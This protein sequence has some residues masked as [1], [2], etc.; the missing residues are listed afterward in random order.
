M[1]GAPDIEDIQRKAESGDAAAQYLLAGLLSRAGRREEAERWLQDAARANCGDAI[2]T[3]A[4][5]RLHTSEG[6]I[7]TAPKVDEAATRGSRAAMALRAV[8]RLEG[9]GFSRDETQAIRD[10]VKAA[11][12]GETAP[13]RA[14]ASTLLLREVDDGDARSLLETAARTD[15]IAAA[16]LAAR[17]CAGRAVSDASLLEGAKTRLRRAHY[18]RT[19]AVSAATVQTPAVA[20]P[21][22]P[23]WD[24]L[25]QRISEA[26]SFRSTVKREQ[27]CPAPDIAVYRRTVPDEVCEYLIAHAAL[28]LGPS[29]VYNPTSGSMMQDPLR[30]S[31]TACLALLD[32]DLAVV[33]VNR[34][35]AAYAGLEHEQGEFLSIL[36]YAPGQLYRPHLDCIPSGPDFDRNGQRVRTALLYLNDDYEGGETHFLAPDLRFRGARGDIIVFSN[37]DAASRPD[38]LSRHAGLA[39][40]RGEKWLGSRWFRDRAFRF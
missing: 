28:R 17:A 25:P 24:L 31:S 12:Q 15:V 16:A 9:V 21:H 13:M 11:R 30:T 37:V 38:P 29:L 39:V 40:T 6:A 4:T 20:A 22:E 23:D 5:R 33:A 36:R 3:L 18:P 2:Y 26:L 34:L 14:L 1:N 10:I 32:L 8:M 27:I 35:M 19:E 7:E